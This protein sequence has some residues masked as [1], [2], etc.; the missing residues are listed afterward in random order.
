[1]KQKLLIATAAM[2]ALLVGCSTP[3]PTTSGGK[4][5]TPS[6]TGGSVPVTK[7]E[8]FECDDD[9]ILEPHL[10]AECIP[11]EPPEPVAAPKPD[12]IVGTYR[13]YYVDQ[14]KTEA[15]LRFKP[16]GT[17]DFTSIYKGQTF[18]WKAEDGIYAVHESKYRD[19][20][21]LF[22]TRYQATTGEPEVSTITLGPRG[23]A[24][25]A[26]KLSNAPSFLFD[27][28]KVIKLFPEESW[29]CKNIGRKP[30][31]MASTTGTFM[32]IRGH[33]DFADTQLE[34]EERCRQ[35]ES[36]LQGQIR[37]LHTSMTEQK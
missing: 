7:E 23:K 36:H 22:T 21:L 13:A 33:P 17:L 6:G 25:E 19:F 28:Y 37:C 3:T 15:I 34:C 9:L 20:Q 35:I 2:L 14:P 12:P 30:E 5:G 24:F 29:S 11:P 18:S 32:P 16:D 27:F 4:V 10:P 26:I 8:T 1:M 31:L